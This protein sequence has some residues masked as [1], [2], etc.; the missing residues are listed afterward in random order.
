M[1]STYEKFMRLLR[2]EIESLHDEIEIILKS[3]DERLANH[4][5][6]DYVHNENGAILRNELLG[7]EDFLKAEFD[8]SERG[9][10]TLDEVANE[11]R[12]YLRKRV[13]EREYVPALY[14]LV[15][16]RIEKIMTYLSETVPTGR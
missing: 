10:A 16:R 3:L 14:D 2:L 9:E 4:E 13:Y 7:L 12:A 1:I 6:T 8:V 15:D 5:I 11:V